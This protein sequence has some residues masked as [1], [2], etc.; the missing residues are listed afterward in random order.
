LA[1]EDMGLK[2]A[3]FRRGQPV[4]SPAA[5]AEPSDADGGA[6]VTRWLHDAL[7][8]SGDDT[9]FP[10]QEELL[11]RFAQ[12]RID[13]ALD[14]PTGLGK[15]AVMAIWLVARASGANLPR[16][17]VYIVDRRAVVDQA[18]ETAMKLR[19]LVD[20]NAALKNKLGLGEGRPLPISTL[21]GQY[22]D[23]KEWLE[24]PVSPAIIVGTVDMI[25][26]RLLFEGY[27]VSRKM[28]PYHAGLLGADTL[29][30]LDEAHLVSSFEELLKTV[31][32][33]GA[34]FRPREE[35]LKRMVPP[36]RI[37][38]LSATG[39]STGPGV[40][41][42]TNEDLEHSIAKKRLG[43]EKHLSVRQLDAKARLEDAL[44][45]YAWELSTSGTRPV[46]CIVFCDKREV[47]GRV[48]RALEKLA[49]GDKKAGKAAT[50]VDT[51][52]FVGGRR[53][54][55]R[56]NVK[57]R[58]KQLGFIAGS[59]VE[60]TRPAFLSATSAAEVGVD[61]DADHM[62]CDLVSWERMVQR[63]GRVNR[64]GE[65]EASVVVVS[66]Q[67]PEGID[68]LLRKTAESRTRK[69][70][71]TVERVERVRAVRRLLEQLPRSGDVHDASPGALRALKQ[72]AENDPSLTWMFDAATTPPPL[73]PAL[74]RA[75]VD[76][77][78]MTSLEKHTGRPAIGPWLRGWIKDDPPQTAVV[79][80]TH[81]PVRT[82]VIPAT[83]REVEAFFEAAPPH[84]SE[85]LGTET[86]RVVEWLEGRAK[87][88]SSG[89]LDSP[90]KAAIR[91]EDV[92]AFVL[93]PEGDLRSA[94]RLADLAPADN[95]RR[96]MLEEV[97]AGATLVVDARLGGLKDGLL[98]D[99]EGALP[100]TV[101]DGKKWLG[102][103]VVR[104]RVRSAEVT[105]PLARDAQWRERLR[106]AADVSAEGEPE[107]WLIVEKWRHDA[108]TEED[109]SAA[110]PQRLEEHQCWAEERARDLAKRLALPDEYAEMLAI[111]ARLHDEGKCA[112]RW[113]RA[114]NAAT[115]GMY[116]K[117]RGPIN[118]TLLDG[119]RH[120][121]GAVP[122][123]EKNDRL[124]KLPHEL[125][126]L[127][128]HL[129][130]AHHGF[131]RP[132]IGTRGCE[133]APP[134]ALEDRAA[135]IAER[136][137]L[138][139]KRWGPWGLAWWEALLRA[140]DQQASRD[141]DALEAL[142]ATDSV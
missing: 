86:F 100:R 66:E 10:W 2:L 137:A 17:L 47:A 7:A 3:P 94:L 116:A 33:D 22:V 39:R 133:D 131:A 32:D 136:F 36:F 54:F 11:R 121:L 70:A 40:F 72:R 19:E 24:D 46:R 43:A 73:R 60:R 12:G 125:R 97:L 90:E 63:L 25:G 99:E 105:E 76:A 52:L 75:V 93:T 84:V 91:K 118:Y 101:D 112:K 87:A 59:K 8:L 135:K 103:A 139:Q 89:P 74:S 69:E 71:E 115:D 16:R 49:R 26:S 23:N 56:E 44:A 5:H 138:L 53:V 120:E 129:I 28:R 104:F 1:E 92:A 64:R 128:L 41:G 15:T 68:D 127:A 140:A 45:E 34:K 30:V 27:G 42:L 20:R 88:L 134:S 110:R 119:Y 62:V 57:E 81:L 109:R 124:L 122:H 35:P 9:P 78:A 113:Q 48:K 141:N 29:I 82:G 107:R 50:G 114:F 111:A 13:H 142:A 130:A 4:G 14:I 123:A 102:E 108:T 126:E 77:W 21:R 106:F 67:E 58:L 51:E 96:A 98:D 61:L 95:R 79:W 18:T 37:L 117:T 132:V 55:E 31:A 38:S 65:G 6:L 80:R 85:L 83:K